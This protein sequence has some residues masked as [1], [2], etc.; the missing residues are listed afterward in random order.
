[1]KA[2]AYLQVVPQFSSSGR[3]LG[4]RLAKMS[5]RLP[6]EPLA[7]ALLLRVVVEVPDQVLAPIDVQVQVPADAI[8]RTAAATAVVVPRQAGAT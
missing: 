3:V 8:A 1:M 6:R 4:I 2:L 5:T 7:G